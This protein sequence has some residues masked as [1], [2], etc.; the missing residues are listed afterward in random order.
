[1]KAVGAANAAL[2]E[3][4]DDRRIIELEAIQDDAE[5]G[6]YETGFELASEAGEAPDIV[7]SEAAHKARAHPRQLWQ[8]GR[9]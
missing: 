2:A 8:A 5:W 9:A 7:C 4:G 6:D 1:V 3:A